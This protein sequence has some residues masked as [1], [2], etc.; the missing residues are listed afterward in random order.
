[1]IPD[2]IKPPVGYSPFLTT[3]AKGDQIYQCALSKGGFSWETLAPD[4]KLFDNQ[5]NIVGNHS[6][7]P[8]WEYKEGSRVKGR[9]IKKIDKT[10]DSSIAWLLVEVVSLKRSGLLSKAHFVNRI[11]T[12]GGLPPTSGCDANHLGSEKRIA[13]SAD[14][15]FYQ[16]D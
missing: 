14:Y 12:H 9:I 16:K 13:Y 1:M 6:A 2:S 7:G 15:I 5:G 10:S 4:A 8:I 11:N 3:H